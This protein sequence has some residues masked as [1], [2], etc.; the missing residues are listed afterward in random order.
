MLPQTESSWYKRC[1]EQRHYQ[2]FQPVFD[3]RLISINDKKR[4]AN[5]VVIIDNS[6]LIIKIS[7]RFTD[8]LSTNLTSSLTECEKNGT[9]R[10]MPTWRFSQVCGVEATCV[11][12]AN[13]NA[14]HQEYTKSTTFVFIE[15]VIICLYRKGFKRLRCR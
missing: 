12:V 4:R 9:Y 13:D 15:C 10:V 11:W 7:S 3:L 2:R 8:N 1:L 14:A 5:G 6:F